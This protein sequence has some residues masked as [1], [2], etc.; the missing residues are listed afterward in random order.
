MGGVMR[1]Y[2]IWLSSIFV[3]VLVSFA[4]LYLGWVAAAIVFFVLAVTSLP[5]A[6]GFAVTDRIVAWRNR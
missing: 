6:A 3:S 2:A 4:A 5:A 1:N